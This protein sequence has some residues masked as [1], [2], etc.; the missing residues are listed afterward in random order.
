MVTN[1]MGGWANLQKDDVRLM[2]D[3][4]PTD[5][6]HGHDHPSEP[7]MTG[8]PY[9]NIDAVDRLAIDLG[10]KVELAFGPQ[11]QPHGRREPVDGG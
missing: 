3:Q 1:R 4:L 6:H 2:F 5:E 9:S 11:T 8:S 10:G 7:T